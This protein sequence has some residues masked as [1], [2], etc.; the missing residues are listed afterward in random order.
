MS[1][2][3]ATRSSSPSIAIVAPC[4]AASARS[5]SANATRGWNAPGLGAGGHRRREHLGAQ[6]PAGMDDRLTRVQPQV[7]GELRDGVVRHGQD[8]QLDVVDERGGLGERPHVRH[9]LAE[10]A[11]AAGIPRGNGADRPA[12]ARQRD[13]QREARRSRPPRS[14]SPGARPGSEW[15][16]G[17]TWSLACSRS[18]CRWWPGVAGS[19]SIPSPSSSRSVSAVSSARR[20]A[21]RR[22][23]SSISSQALIDGRLPGGGPRGTLPPDECSERSGRAPGLDRPHA[24]TSEIDPSRAHAPTPSVPAPPSAPASRTSTASTALATRRPRRSASISGVRR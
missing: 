14:P 18:P 2:R 4:S 16:C 23:A 20:S 21:A 11:P 3:C 12:G 6:Q 1:A 5:R 17:W 10:P 15:A 22:T 8:D 7:P 19:R 24:P 9:V 13:A